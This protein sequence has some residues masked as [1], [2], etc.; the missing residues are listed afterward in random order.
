MLETSDPGR[1]NKLVQR[2]IGK[3]YEHDKEHGTELVTTL[4]HYLAAGGSLI[5]AANRLYIHRNSVKYRM[6]RIK[7]MTGMDLDSA[8]SR[9][10]LYLCTVYSLLNRTD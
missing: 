6:D 3:L 2:N 5:E 4:Y 10:E 1:L 8:S 7:E 9:F